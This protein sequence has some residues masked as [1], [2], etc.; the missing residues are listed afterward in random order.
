MKTKPY[1]NFLLLLTLISGSAVDV[2][3]YK[4]LYAEQFYELYH[5]HLTQSP[6]DTIENIIWLQQS[7]KADFANPLNALATIKTKEEW[8]YYQNLFKMHVNILLTQQHMTLGSKFDK[9]NAYFYNAPWA[10]ANI[11]SLNKAERA[12][13][14]ATAYWEEAKRWSNLATTEKI[15]GINLEEIQYWEDQNYRI[16]TGDFDYRFIIAQHLERLSKVKNEFQKMD[17]TTY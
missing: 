14:T 15:I 8:R 7:L 4:I 11:D 3:A 2:L 9:F 5:L 1:F 13:K 12:Y 6:D 16:E 10:W 17:E